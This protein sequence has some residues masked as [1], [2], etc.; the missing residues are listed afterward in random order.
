MSVKNKIKIL[1]IEDHPA[2]LF[3]VQQLLHTNTYTIIEASNGK[4]GIKAAI[5]TIP[6]LILIDMVMSDMSGYEILTQFEKEPRLTDIPKIATS[7]QPLPPK[8]TPHLTP[9]FDGF[10]KKPIDITTFETQLRS[11]LKN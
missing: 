9:N 4:D 10:I 1:Y 11:F 2:S 6:D 5:T 7:A 3:L 8:N